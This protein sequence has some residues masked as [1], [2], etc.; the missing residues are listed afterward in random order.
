M[1]FKCVTF[2]KRKKNAHACK[3]NNVPFLERKI[4]KVGDYAQNEGVPHFGCKQPGDI[5][6]FS[7]LSVYIFGIVR[8][9]KQE[10]ELIS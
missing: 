5:Y 1:R 7:P 9:Y 3:D 6:Y 4:T 8:L 10:T 2:A